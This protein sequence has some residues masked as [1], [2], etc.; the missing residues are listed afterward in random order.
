MKPI[1]T[2][3]MLA[4]CAS[5]TAADDIFSAN[6]RLGR[7][8]N[9]GNY[10][11]APRGQD[12]GMRLEPGDFE[13][14]KKAGFNSIRLP[15]KWSS[16]A[17]ANPPFTI[18]ADFL[19]RVDGYLDLAEKAGLNVVLN[20]HHYDELDGNTEAEFDRFAALWRQIGRRY[21]SRPDSLFFELNNE[22]HG[23]LDDARWNA[24]LRLGLKAVRE[25]NPRRPVIIGPA[26]WNN[27]RALPGLS[28]PDDPNLIVTVHYYNP[29]EFTH[30]GAEWTDPKVRAL[31]NV[32][33]EGDAEQLATLR[34]DLDNAAHWAK[35]H[36][37]PLFLGEFGAYG[38]AP[39]E[40]RARWTNAVAREAEARGMSW[41]YW[42]FAAGFGVFDRA[43][44]QWRR[45]LLD[46]LAPREGKRA[47]A[48][49][50]AV[51]DASPRP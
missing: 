48:T 22:P 32:A 47:S 20:I 2:L 26:F 38:K 14:I 10:L 40:S 13:R 42:E 35:T 33:W 27:I 49:S 23:K 34:G 8:V 39:L 46:A 5:N 41:A 29:F 19:Q 1:L 37:R 21:A 50:G 31:R 36:N 12:W 45:P 25:S 51:G 16:Y 44:N 3:I 4:G 15:V 17:L 6:R 9:I 30:Q 11:E 43:K 7:G 24:A 18:E 28:L